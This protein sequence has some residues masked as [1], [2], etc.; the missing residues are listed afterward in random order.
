MKSTVRNQQSHPPL[1]KGTDSLFSFCESVCVWLV[2]GGFGR[3]RLESELDEDAQRLYCA[4]IE[5][6]GTALDRS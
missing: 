1:V 3:W 6:L 5:L 2:V 4:L